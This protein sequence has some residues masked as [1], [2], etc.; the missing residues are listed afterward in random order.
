MLFHDDPI[1]RPPPQVT[2]SRC[3]VVGVGDNANFGT[4]PIQSKYRASVADT[5]TDTDTDTN[6]D[7]FYLKIPD[8]W[9]ILYF[10]LLIS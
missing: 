4:D 7:T 9:M 8:H 3:S 5:D 1:T 2:S 10:C 6:T